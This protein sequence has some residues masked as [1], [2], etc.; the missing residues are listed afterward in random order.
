M[1]SAPRMLYKPPIKNYNNS[2]IPWSTK[3][4]RE[5]VNFVLRNKV[6]IV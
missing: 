5:N 4:Q 6:K 2:Q 1:T 3:E